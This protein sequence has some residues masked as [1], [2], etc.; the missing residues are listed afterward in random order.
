MTT[1]P[2][3]VQ[4]IHG[5]DGSPAFAVLPYDE[6]ER[7][8]TGRA[9]AYIPHAV[10][11]KMIEGASATRAWR[12]QLGLTQEEMASRMD[13]SQAAYSQLENSAK[14]RPSSRRR[15][16]EALGIGIEQLV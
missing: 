12:E 2:T 5:A 13:I 10:V 1:V 14:L 3:D 15:I 6:Y 8:S 11:G 9:K 4:I 16:A 7:L